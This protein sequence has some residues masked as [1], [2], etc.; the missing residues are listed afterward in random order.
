MASTLLSFNSYAIS[1]QDIRNCLNTE[2]YTYYSAFIQ[3]AEST[4]TFQNI[5]ENTRTPSAL[6]CSVLLTENKTTFSNGLLAYFLQ[7]NIDILPASLQ[8][9]VIPI[10]SKI[11][12]ET[13][14]TK[15]QETLHA[16]F[17][18]IWDSIKE[19]NIDAQN[20]I[21]KAINIENLANAYKVELILQSQLLQIEMFINAL[22]QLSSKEH[23][24]VVSM[25]NMMAI[26]EYLRTAQWYEGEY[27][28]NDFW[29]IPPSPEILLIFPSETSQQIKIAKYRAYFKVKNKALSLLK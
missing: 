4:V 10:I 6:S 17:Y 25:K 2:D 19:K 29:D 14:T 3:E 9:E 23:L 12:D 16:K 22:Y 13:L 26:Q 24:L 28:N 20:Q 1:Q 8:Q 21:I 7:Q 5:L 18:I 27:I 11:A 15:E